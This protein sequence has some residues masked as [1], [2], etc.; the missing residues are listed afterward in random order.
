MKTE[1]TENDYQFTHFY[2][3]QT[4]LREGNVFTPVCLS[5]CSGGRVAGGHAR[6]GACVAEGM[7]CRE[8]RMQERRH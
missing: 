4:K 7:C 6:Y 3:P 8:V 1:A 5:L 2:R